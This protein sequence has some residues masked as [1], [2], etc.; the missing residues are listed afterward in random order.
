MRL[1]TRLP[2]GSRATEASPRSFTCANDMQR[3]LPVLPLRVD[4]RAVPQQRRGDADVPILAC[5]V[6]R[7]APRRVGHVDEVGLRLFAA[8]GVKSSR[9]PH[10]SGTQARLVG[11]AARFLIIPTSPSAEPAR[12]YAESSSDGRAYEGRSA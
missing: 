5:G 3:G 2:E 8:H 12:M 9:C 10:P 6:Q 7:R 1:A 11:A 4:I